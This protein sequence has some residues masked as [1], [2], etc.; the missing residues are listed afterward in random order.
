MDRDT[1][2]GAPEGAGFASRIFHWFDQRTGVQGFAKKVLDEHIPGG[3]RF[4]YVFG[5]GLLFIFLLQGITGV[6]L[7]LYYTPTAE[8]AHTSVA[9]ISKQVAGGAFLRSLHSYGSSAMIIVLGLHFLQ[10]FLFGSFKGRRELLWLS[11]ALLSFLVLGMGFT[12]YL[13]PWD[14]KAYF[15]TAVGTNIMGQTPLIGNLLTRLVRGGDTIGTLTLSRFYVAHVFLIPATIFLFIGAHVLLFRKAGPA[16]PVEEHPITPKLPPEHF[17]PRQVFMDM[18]FVLVIMAAL[19][20]LSYFHPTTLG[21]IA[22][23]A[24]THF[25]PRPEWYYLPMFEWL[26]FWEGPYVVVGVMVLP[27]L[28]AMVFFLMPFLDRKLERSPWRRPIPVL[29]VAIV[30]FGM[31]F[32][33]A[34]SR[35]DDRH[36]P[37]VA[38]QLDLQEEQE[39]IYSF[40]PFEPYL[41]SPDEMKTA[42]VATGS[43]DPLVAVGKGIFTTRGCVGCHG[44]TGMGTAV[45]PSLAGVTHKFVEA[46]LIALLHNPSLKMR[47]ARMPVV[48]APPAEMSALVAYLGAL[49]TSATNVTPVYN[50]PPSQLGTGALQKASYAVNT[51]PVSKGINQAAPASLSASAAAGQQLFQESACFACHGQAG[52]GGRAPALAPLVAKLSDAQLI[53]LLQSPSPKM[54]AGGMPPVA[55]PPDQMGSLISYLRTLPMPQ[56]GKPIAKEPAQSNEASQ[57]ETHPA[58]PVYVSLNNPPAVPEGNA[59]PKAIVDSSVTP[60]ASATTPPGSGRQLF[61]ARGCIA[62]HGVNAQGTQIAP[63]LIGVSA[64]FSGDKLPYLLR[65]PSNKMRDGGMPPV[66]VNDEQ[67]AELVVY[68]SSL[69]PAPISRPDTQTHIN[70][71]V[72]A[73]QPNQTPVAVSEST[74]EREVVDVPLNPLAAR[75][76]QIFQR[77]ACGTCHGEGGV[78][79][80]IAAPGLAGTASLLAESKIDSL[81]RHHTA[82][83]NRGGMPPT[84]FNLQDMKSVVAYIRSMTSAPE[85]KLVASETGNKK[86]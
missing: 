76:K 26:K 14:Q 47:A 54:K 44:S 51:S 22:N 32:L 83:M 79:G 73:N 7:A 37:D 64:R 2:I 24:D 39:K 65:H 3:G 43:V 45:A 5:S 42:L 80:T 58:T 59:N 17:Y 12:G 77:S 56:P 69:Q 78:N 33:G 16:G 57:Q 8:T 61:I 11:G 67:M 55:A 15:A 72:S 21:P 52:A 62:C 53:Q 82:R 13:L 34:K 30:V 28:L 19:A 63:S 35:I 60:T 86:N 71:K 74:P 27:G 20:G 68:L 40:A 49:G 1:D 36:N 50:M 6:S 75:G 81:L 25:L 46:D 31:V 29:A 38:A 66:T 18:A 9:Y 41:E 84:N 10:T 70:P 48:N 85:R 4:A 23:P